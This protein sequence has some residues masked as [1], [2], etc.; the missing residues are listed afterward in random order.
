MG[1]DDLSNMVIENV[2]SVLTM[3]TEQNGG[4]KRQNRASWGI[5][6]KYEGETIYRINGKTVTSN[7]NNIVILPKGCSYEWTCVRAGHFIV[8]EFESKQEWKDIIAVSL[9]NSDKIYN[10]FRKMEHIQNS[11]NTFGKMESIKEC[12]SLLI[13]ALQAQEKKYQPTGKQKKVAPAMDYILAHY[14]ENITN[15]VLAKE[16][17]CSTV[18][19]RKLFAEIYGV[20]PGAFIHGKR[21]EKAKEMLRSDYGSITNVAQ[22]LGYS[23]IYDFSRSFKTHTGFLPSE[24][25]KNAEKQ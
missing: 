8:I 12:Y 9:R 4:G 2:S 1:K 18:Y 6:L 13:M 16:V 14:C 3:F 24:Y 5:I 11:N 15:D 7:K 22:A 25:I 23:S 20:S 19:F 10:Q 17:G 21:I